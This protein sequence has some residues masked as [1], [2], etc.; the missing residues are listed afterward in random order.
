VN[1]L[2]LYRWRRRLF[3][4]RLSSS[5]KLVA[6]VLAEH[7]NW[8]SLECWPSVRRV[9]REASLARSTVQL[10]LNELVAG[11]FIWRVF[12]GSKPRQRTNLY[13]LTLPE[14]DVN[15]SAEANDPAF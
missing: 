15:P 9:A 4:A 6:C 7:A 14:L 5:A 11:G 3:A 13:R 2:T 12:R 10:A 8:D 1:D